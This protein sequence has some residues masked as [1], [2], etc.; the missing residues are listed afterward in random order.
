MYRITANAAVHATSSKRKPPAHRAPSTTSRADRRAPRERCPTVMAESTAG[1]DELA[2]AARRAAAEAARDRDP[3]GRLRPAA[4]GD[5]RGARHLRGGGEG[6]APPRPASGCA[7]LLYDETGAEVGPCGVTTSP[8]LLPA[9]RRRRRHRSSSPRA[10]PHR[11][12]P[13]LSGRARPLPADAPW[14]PAQLRTQLLEP[15]PGLLA[16]TLAAIERS[17]PSS[18][19]SARCSPG[20]ASPTRAAIGGA[21]AAAGATAAAVARRTAPAA[22]PRSPR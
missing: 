4:R 2:D 10:A 5:R 16:T 19:R 22:A 20:G 1:L 7:T 17:R 12:V 9:A 11:V 3:Q 14:P 6:A 13:A 8:L 15:A 21:V 18:G